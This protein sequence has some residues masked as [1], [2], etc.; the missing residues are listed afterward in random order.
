MVD[1]LKYLA[2]MAEVEIV[3]YGDSP[4]RDE[5]NRRI[6][7]SEGITFNH[8]TKLD[9][10][11]PNRLAIRMVAHILESRPDLVVPVELYYRHSFAVSVFHRKVYSY[12]FQNIILKR[13][14]MMPLMKRL[15]RL[16]VPVPS[17]AKVWVRQGFPA[18]KIYVIPFGV[19]SLRFR[20]A[21]PSW[22][23]PKILYVGRLTEEKG[24][25]YLLRGLS[26]LR[27]PF[28][29]K[30]V[31]GGEI[32]KFASLA[33]SLKLK[34]KLQFV[35]FVE[36]DRLH[37]F[38]NWSNIFIMPSLVVGG[39]AEQLGMAL[40]EAMA[41]GRAVIGSRTGAIPDV[42]GDSGILVS[43]KSDTAITKAIEFLVRNPD[44]G[45]E[46]SRRARNRVLELFDAKSCADRLYNAFIGRGK[47]FASEI[48]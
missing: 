1:T 31:G 11:S 29:A 45:A 35:P 15:S 9:T 13:A 30:F 25:A 47:S 41:Y 44:K 4:A 37:E 18:T 34:E 33:S 43:E 42:I 8:I 5:Q 38:Y 23:M 39:W 32:A 27:M 36:R 2:K 14:K 26:H 12:A 7:E 21:K 16:I 46:L 19:D 40:I 6:F 17:T 24:I 48:S 3:G 22:D 10:S 28:E 20:G